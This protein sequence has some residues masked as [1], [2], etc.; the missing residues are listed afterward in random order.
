MCRSFSLKRVL[1]EAALSKVEAVRVP[2]SEALQLPVSCWRQLPCDC[3]ADNPWASNTCV[4]LMRIQ[5]QAFN[6]NDFLWPRSEIERNKCEVTKL[7]YCIARPMRR[8]L[9]P[10]PSDFGF[11]NMIIT[12]LIQ[13]A[14]TPNRQVSTSLIRHTSAALVEAK[15]PYKAMQL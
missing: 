8:C 6:E 11:I 3:A 5:K 15:Q 13:T 14:P 7:L 12:L 9:I 2:F 4:L 1:G 10:L